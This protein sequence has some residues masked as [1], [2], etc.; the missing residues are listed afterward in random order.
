[1]ISVGIRHAAHSSQWL[2]LFQW[3]PT[4]ALLKEGDVWKCYRALYFA[5]Y[6]D[7]LGVDLR[8]SSDESTVFTIF[9]FIA[10][11]CFAY[12]LLIVTW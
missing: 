12:I 11:A 10:G 2:P 9:V 8:P 7:R 4:E 5:I 6:L 3:L 1:M